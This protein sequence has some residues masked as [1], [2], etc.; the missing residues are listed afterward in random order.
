MSGVSIITPHER[1]SS[2]WTITLVRCAFPIKRS[3]TQW[4]TLCVVSNAN[5]TFTLMMSK[6]LASCTL[7]PM[8]SNNTIYMDYLSLVQRL[9][10]K[11]H[12]QQPWE[13]DGVSFPIVII[14][15]IWLFMSYITIGRHCVPFLT[16]KQGWPFP[17]TY[18]NYNIK[19]LCPVPKNHAIWLIS[20]NHSITLVFILNSP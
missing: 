16:F 8:S 17:I 1:Y 5:V 10:K 15:T 12:S 20:S 19:S 9:K 14:Y 4:F 2:C 18:N 11:F 7:Y 3:I 6:N 13:F